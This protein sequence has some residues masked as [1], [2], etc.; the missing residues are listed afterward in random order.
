MLHGFGGWVLLAISR[1]SEPWTISRLTSSL[2]SWWMASLSPAFLECCACSTIVLNS[3]VFYAKRCNPQN[4]DSTY[5]EQMAMDMIFI[6]VTR[7][8][9]FLSTVGIK[10]YICKMSLMLFCCDGPGQVPWIMFVQ[11]WE[12]FCSFK[13]LEIDPNE[14]SK[15]IITWKPG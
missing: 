12:S 8:L 14:L 11:S 4:I 7:G 1:A 5:L 15:R 13:G 2:R 9:A 10:W 3:R 6:L